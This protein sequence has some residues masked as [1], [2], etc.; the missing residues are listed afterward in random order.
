MASKIR[1]AGQTLRQDGPLTLADKS[2]RYISRRK[3]AWTKYLYRQTLPEGVR[4]NKSLRAVKRQMAREQGLDDII[5][6]VVNV[7]PGIEPYHVEAVQVESEIRSL[8]EH[9]ERSDPS[10]ILEIGTRHGG[11]LYVWARYLNEVEHIISLDLPG[12]DFGGGY[13]ESKIPLYEEFAPDKE[14]D[15]LRANSH[16]P[17]TYDRVADLSEGEVDFLFIDG[18]HTYEG[19]KQDFEMYKRLVSDGG[20]IA[21]HDIV[22]RPNNPKSNVKEL[23]DEVV[24]E[25][26]VTEYVGDPDQ[27]WG[28]IGIVEI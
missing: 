19:V 24:E 3:R 9:V 7:R 1:R 6:T 18:D 17:E 11:T 2:L 25:Y 20:L 13:K 26:D 27:G 4:Y 14:M 10:R 16:K 28:G 12:A 21:F 5:D 8:A 23:W 22:E 15:F